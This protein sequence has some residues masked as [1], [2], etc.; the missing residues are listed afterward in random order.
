M[1]GGRQDLKRGDWAGHRFDITTQARHDE[2]TKGEEWNDIS[3]EI[4]KNVR[5]LSKNGYGE[6]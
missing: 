1:L 4:R 5:Q 2:E 6:D 3:E